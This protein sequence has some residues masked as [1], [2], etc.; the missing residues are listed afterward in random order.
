VPSGG[1]HERRLPENA[2]TG[3]PG[4]IIAPWTPLLVTPR[5]NTKP[6]MGYGGLNISYSYQREGKDV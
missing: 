3:A 4:S 2:D 6:V 1:N 5:K